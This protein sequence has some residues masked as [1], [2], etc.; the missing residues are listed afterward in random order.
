MHPKYSPTAWL[1]I[2][3]SAPVLLI[4]GL[5]IYFAAIRNIKNSPT[6]MLITLGSLSAFGWSI[7]A[8]ITGTLPIHAE[9]AATVIL[10]AVLGQYFSSLAIHRAN[11]RLA[12]LLNLRIKEVTVIRHGESVRIGIDHL[13][14]GDEFTTKVGERIATDG[15]VLSGESA[16]D[17][18]LITGESLPIEVGPGSPVIGTSLNRNGHLLIRASR[19]G[20]NT[21]LARLTAMSASAVQIKPPFQRSAERSG[22]LLLPIVLTVA[23][24]TFLGWHFTHHS[25]AKSISSAIAVLVIASPSAI[26]LATPL[27][28]RRAFGKGSQRGIVIRQPGALQ[29]AAKINSVVLD[30]TGTLSGGHMVLIHATVVPVAGAILGASY[31]ELLNDSSILSTALSIDSHSNHPVAMAISTYVKGKGIKPYAVTDFSSTPGIGAAGRVHIDSLVP[32]VLIGSVEAVAHSSTP[33]HPDLTSAVS[34]AQNRG[35]TASVLAWDGVALAVFAVGDEMKPDAPRT[36]AELKDRGIDPWLITAK[37]I[38]AAYAVASQVGIAEDQ[39]IANAAPQQKVELVKALQNHN[40]RVLMVGDGINDE[41]ALASADLSISMGTGTETEIS[42]ADI[43]VMRPDLKSIIDALDFSKKTFRVIRVNLF[44]S[45]AYNAVGITVAAVG[46]VPPIY[47][48]G[49]MLL[50]RLFVITNSLRIK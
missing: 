45:I 12:T 31:Q 47:A 50:S 22:A 1:V 38:E 25:L 21:E 5:P 41:V 35:L 34:E 49:A 11:R 16:V 46:V 26:L 9:V 18:S 28:L 42:P 3:L 36:I 33:F 13:I 48:A 39:V 4:V 27:A 2:G 23:V 15:V 24:G 40:Y 14:V 6:N 17:N 7:Y 10:L 44:W 32:V 37:S 20:S 30:K 8:N 19:I 43:T 29:G